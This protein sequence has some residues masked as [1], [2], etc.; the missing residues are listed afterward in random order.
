MDYILKYLKFLH[1]R[2]LRRWDLTQG[3]F[4]KR[5]DFSE[6]GYMQKKR[7]HIPYFDLWFSRVGFS[8]LGY[9]QKEIHINSR[10]PKWTTRLIFF[11]GMSRP[12]NRYRY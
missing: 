5:F 7:I 8:K 10:S 6:R 9:M 1:V 3:G 11:R 12:V 2:F 4:L